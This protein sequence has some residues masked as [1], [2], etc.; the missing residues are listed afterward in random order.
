[1][2]LE[3]KQKLGDNVK[4]AERKPI[5]LMFT[6]IAS[7]T[8]ISEKLSASEVVNMLNLYFKKANFLFK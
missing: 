1:M 7:F 5:A 6:D 2:V 8:D 4:T 3:K